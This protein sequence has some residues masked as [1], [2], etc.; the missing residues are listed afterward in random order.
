MS[1]LS[2]AIKLTSV[3]SKDVQL[4]ITVQLFKQTDGQNMFLLEI[5]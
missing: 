5:V 4:L 3:S 2:A 1:N